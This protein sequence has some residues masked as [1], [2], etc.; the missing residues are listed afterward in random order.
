VIGVLGIL[1]NRLNKISASMSNS[2]V[3][4]NFRDTLQLSVNQGFEFAS[5]YYIVKSKNRTNGLWFDMGVRLTKPYKIELSSSLRDDHYEVIFKDSTYAANLGD[6]FE[7][8][9]YRY[10]VIDI[11]RLKSP[12]S[13][14]MVQRCN[15][16]LKFMASNTA[17]ISAT[18]GSF[19]TIDGVGITNLSMPTENKMSNLSDD[20]IR[21]SIPNDAYGRLINY[22]VNGGTK[23]L[24][25][26]PL[27]A[28]SCVSIDNITHVRRNVNNTDT[29][30][31]IV[32][33]LSNK[34]SQI[35]SFVDN[36]TLGIA[37]QNCY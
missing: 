13:S 16:Q 10:M 23:F 32:L 17:V 4:S 7:F 26:N 31:F 35:N 11:S 28:Y 22:S 36:L 3:A 15:L 8:S 6:M 30:G 25:G 12:T 2:D 27:K 24:L 33:K 37:K 14:C 1:S 19:L 18:P 5:D 29:N 21:V 9:D 20:E 34:G